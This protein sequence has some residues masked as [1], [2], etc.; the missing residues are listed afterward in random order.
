MRH[1]PRA[2]RRP[3][4]VSTVLSLVLAAPALV[5][6]GCSST[7]GTIVASTLGVAGLAVVGQ[8]VATRSTLEVEVE[9]FEPDEDLLDAFH[10]THLPAL[11]MNQT[12]STASLLAVAEQLRGVDEL[13]NTQQ[14]QVAT[15]AKQLGKARVHEPERVAAVVAF[16][17]LEDQIADSAELITEF[18]RAAADAAMLE[19]AARREG[20]ID[21][22]AASRRGDAFEALAALQQLARKPIELPTEYARYVEAVLR[23][24]G[25]AEPAILDSPT[26][27]PLIEGLSHVLGSVGGL[28]RQNA[29]AGVVE[30]G[31]AESSEL[32]SRLAGYKDYVFVQFLEAGL[33]NDQE[34][35]ALSNA[36]EVG[37]ATQG[38]RF[39]GM[40]APSGMS[41]KR[42]VA[43][44]LAPTVAVGAVRATEAAEELR[45]ERL[46][47]EYSPILADANV[48]PISNEVMQTLLASDAIGHVTNPR[49]EDRWRRFA[50]ARSSGVAGDHNVTVYFENLATPI[51]KDSSLDPTKFQ[52]AYSKMFQR[53]FTTVADVFGS[54]L[55]AAGGGT[56]EGGATDPSAVTAASTNLAAV[57]KM[58]AEADKR[59]EA[60]REAVL[61][62]IKI[63]LDAEKAYTAGKEGDLTAAVEEAYK[64]LVA[65]NGS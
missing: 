27:D 29:E 8:A 16:K 11:R 58:A 48:G 53:A 54:P 64:V 40:V 22:Q 35:R 46:A 28:V 6:P 52:V 13:L 4:A 31:V 43:E 33:V 20:V 61:E 1:T 36:M 2:R 18:R 5:A 63:M 21:L 65:T 44:A 23:P 60:D 17:R 55:V 47:I 38:V 24:A 51:L 10:L 57:Q 62:A 7:E 42:A 3:Y 32:G 39:E 59:A 12:V 37:L 45:S 30:H 9:V 25:G 49:N 14:E 26:Q 50:H 19:A 56:G 41:T 34:E 15:F